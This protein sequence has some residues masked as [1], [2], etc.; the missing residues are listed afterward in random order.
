MSYDKLGEYLYTEELFGWYKDV[1]EHG[2]VKAYIDPISD[3]M[4]DREVVLTTG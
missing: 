3:V 2:Y 4:S 1:Y